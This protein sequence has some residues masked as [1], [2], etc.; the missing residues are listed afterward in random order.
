MKNAD[1]K[2]K[3]TRPAVT[4]WPWLGPR[5]AAP[6]EAKSEAHSMKGDGL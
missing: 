3:A 5:R 6:V 1:A 4:T 2:T